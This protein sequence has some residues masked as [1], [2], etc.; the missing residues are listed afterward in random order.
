MVKRPSGNNLLPYSMFIAR[1]DDQHQVPEFPGDEIVK[2]RK[3]DMYCPYRD[4]KGEQPKPQSSATNIPSAST[5]Y[6]PEPSLKEVMRYLWHQE[7]LQLN[8]QSMLQEAFSD[9]KFI[10]LLQVLSTD[11]DSDAES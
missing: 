1:L 9:K 7:R 8:T 3:V 5:R 4:W 6:S 2:I 11:D 10:C